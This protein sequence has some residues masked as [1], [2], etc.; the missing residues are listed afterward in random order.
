MRCTVGQIISI[1]V[2]PDDVLLEIFDFYVNEDSYEGIKKGIEK[3]QTL[4]HVCRRWR[5]VVFGSPRRLNLQLVC[6]QGTPARNMLDIWPSLPLLIC[7]V[8]GHLTNHVDEFLAILE[9]SDRVVEINLDKVLSS[10][11]D[12]V[13][14]AMQVPFPELTHLSLCSNH[15]MVTVLPDSFL[16]GS[17]PRLQFIQLNRIP[18]PGLPKL[19]LSATHLVTLYLYSIPHSGYISPEVMVTVL[20]TLTSLER[21]SLEF[22]SPRSRPDWASRHPPP[23]TR[24]VL[25][26]LTFFL[27]K[28]VCEYLENLMTRTDAPRLKELDI[29]LFNQIV[30]D[31]PQFIQFIR[32]TPTLET[33]DKAQV[34]FEYR[35]AGVHLSSS[36]TSGPGY[37]TLNVGIPC[38]E[39]DWQVSSMEQVCTLCLPPLSTLEDLY[40]YESSHSQ[41]VWQDN[42]ENTLWLELL[43]PFP[44][45]KN[46]YLSKEFTRRIVPSLQELTGGRSTQVLPTLE[47]IFL[48]ELQSSGTIQKGIQQ[49]VAA[50]Q[51]TSHPIA[52]SLWDNSE[53]DMDRFY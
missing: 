24:S 45:V 7:N 49:F 48:Q 52:V 6:T 39:F 8:G 26:A 43:Q 38:M 4:V 5:S 46:L 32:R 3:W 29:T 28:G 13:L 19:L 18:F 23:R 37:G 1:D 10:E 35:D 50:R 51:V 30:F 15:G 42:I 53:E 31:M 14:A 41:P 47:N 27:F 11:L 33:F 16:G 12:K 34:V 2:L 22:E 9:R 40:I 20:S 36:Q 17:A 44:A 21:L 25:P